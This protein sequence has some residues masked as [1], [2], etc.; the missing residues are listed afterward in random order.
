MAVDKNGVY[1]VT[2]DNTTGTSQ[3]L[4][5][6]S[7]DGGVTWSR[8]LTVNDVTTGQ[9]FFP[10]IAASGGVI[11]VAWYDSRLRVNSNG[12][13]TALDVFY[14]KSA[15]AGATFSNNVRITD[16]SFNPNLITFR[17]FARGGSFIG[18]YN[19]IAA[20]PTEAHPVWSDTI[21]ACD[22]IDPALGCI[23]QDI[24]TATVTL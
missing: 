20:T 8:P 9:H 6:R 17:D 19:Q 13:I 5:I 2:D 1:I 11:N 4:F 23:D 24:F 14:A 16:A 21:N 7:T 10:T 22:L 15:D 18:D 12:T 3:I